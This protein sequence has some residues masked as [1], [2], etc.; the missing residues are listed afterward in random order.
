MDIEVKGKKYEMVMCS[1]IQRDGMYLE[2][3]IPGTKPLQQVAEVF[4]SDQ[5]LDFTVSCFHENVPLELL[6]LLINEAKV[7]LPVRDG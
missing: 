1:D 7:R 2:V 6:E 5:T 3:L 4:Y